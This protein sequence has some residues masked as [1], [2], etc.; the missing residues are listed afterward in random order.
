MTKDHR[1]YHRRQAQAATRVLTVNVE[2]IAT[3]DSSGNLVG[4]ET[5]T[6]ADASEST[7]EPAVDTPGGLIPAIIAP[8]ASAVNNVV[9]SVAA[10]VV[11]AA[12][13]VVE[14]VAAPAVSA[15][16]NVVE[17]VVAPIASP[18]VNAVDSIAAP[19]VSGVVGAVVPSVPAVPSVA[20]PTVPSLP[21]VPSVPPFPT[22]AQ[23]VVPS[24]PAFPSNLV[25]PSY[26]W[27]SG[28]SALVAQVSTG[29]VTPSPAPTSMPG[30]SVVPAP[31]SA[32]PSPAANVTSDPTPSLSSGAIASLNSA[33]IF[34][35]ASDALSLDPSGRSSTFDFDETAS[36]RRA[37]AT[38]SQN[39]GT[40][41]AGGAG[42]GA[43][44][45]TALPPG[46]SP[47]AAGTGSSGNSTPLETPQVVGS[48]VGSLAGAALI[49]AI[50]LLLLRRH[51]RKRQ[52]A[53]QLTGDETTERT[54]PMIQDSSRNNRIPSAFLNRFSGL[55]RSTAET[56][57]SGGERSFQRVSGRK[58]P[59]AFSEGMT[60]EQFSRGG[61]MSGSSFYQDDHGTYGGA[62]LSKELEKDLGG[63]PVAAGAG[64]MNIRPSPAR[65]PV[66]RHPDDDVNPFADPAPFPT[67]RTH[68]SPPQSPNPEI[69]RSTLGRSLQ[70]ADGSRSSKFTENV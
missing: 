58:L 41:S 26:P 20:V 35:S 8:V 69:P 23:P 12:N 61:T 32:A 57:T 31:L 66:I 22:A 5:K 16:I 44:V 50:I 28:A 40:T 67:A 54:Q 60:S 21:Q 46:Q 62:G 55:S 33:S 56:T 64:M 6:Q 27:P 39:A 38:A 45:G 4:Q 29:A 9:D 43:A 49:L 63:S 59:S 2:V 36:S 15:V 10:P 70:S 7:P 3:V 51:R 68:L 34:L 11:S 37:S 42:G 48:V 13:N 65:T 52:G 24:V 14:S 1:F 25:V 18:V 47:A 17:S 30:S 53:L 19:V